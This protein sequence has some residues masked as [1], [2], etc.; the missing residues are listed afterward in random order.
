MESSE[1]NREMLNFE[2]RSKKK[3]FKDEICRDASPSSCFL[4]FCLRIQD[5]TNWHVSRGKNR[6]KLQLTKWNYGD[7]FLTLIFNRS[8]TI[9]VR[10]SVIAKIQKKPYNRF[11]WFKFHLIAPWVRCVS[12]LTSVIS[13]EHCI[14]AGSSHSNDILLISHF[15][16]D[17][18]L[19][20][21]CTACVIFF[22]CWTK[23]N[24]KHTVY[25]FF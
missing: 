21:T 23:M 25:V 4:I 12:I 1:D 13:Q 8:L 18:I 22:F 3:S 11:F 2:Q 16:C 24:V 5:S 6:P 7:S 15:L 19:L 20:K 14:M 9:R 10:S 17:D